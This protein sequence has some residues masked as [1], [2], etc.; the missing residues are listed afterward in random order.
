MKPRRFAYLGMQ[1]CGSCGA[2]VRAGWGMIE[3]LS[4]EHPEPR[5]DAIPE[6]EPEA[7]SVITNQEGEG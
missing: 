3:H 4:R 7:W 2:E 6:P 5:Q 1:R